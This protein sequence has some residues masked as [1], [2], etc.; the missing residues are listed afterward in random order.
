MRPRQRSAAAIEGL[1]GRVL[2]AFN[3]YIAGLGSG[4]T[5]SDASFTFST[6]G[7]AAKSWLIHWDD[8]TP[9]TLLNAPNPAV[10]FTTPQTVTHHYGFL[11]GNYAVSATATSIV[12]L[13][14][15]AVLAENAAFTG[16]GPNGGNGKEVSG[17]GDNNSAGT[18]I[19]VASDTDGTSYVLS[20]DGKRFAVSRFTPTGQLDTAW[21]TNGT[22]V[23]PAFTSTTINDI[24]KAMTMDK[25][26]NLLYV[27]GTSND[28][29]AVA[30]VNIDALATVP[31][32]WQRSILT[33]SANA[34]WLDSTDGNTKIG[35]AG[36]NSSSQ[37]Q[38]T[39]LYAVDS[40]DFEGT[41]HSAGT[42]DTSFGGG[43]A[44]ATA[45]NAIYGVLPQYSV[46]ASASAI[47]EGDD[48]RGLGL[49]E[50]WF[51]AGTVT[52]CCGSCTPSGGSDMVI[53]DFLQDG[54]TDTSF[55]NGNGAAL[56]NT[57]APSAV[58]GG[59]YDQANAM[60]GSIIDDS[61]YMTLIGRGGSTILSERFTASGARDTNATTG[62]GVL[63]GGSRPGFAWGP[64]GIIYSATLD[65][66]VNKVVAVGSA[67]GFADF[68]AL[69]LNDDG[70]LDGSFG[71]G[72]VL[73]VDFGPY[74][75]NRTDEGR[76]VVVRTINGVI[77]ILVAGYTYDVV[78]SKYKIALV[79]LLDDNSF[80][81]T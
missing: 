23:L 7:Q 73:T 51:V 69:R 3:A 4:A 47:L 76:S 67:D 33:G 74:N 6:T 32:E 34:L 80:H 56:Y 42:N 61:A 37:I 50:E 45:N 43:T 48:I 39:V 62:Y 5:D 54:S 38:M 25:G 8:G 2:Y 41:F 58:V 64:G 81:V 36:T 49:D 14:A 1:E 79:D 19:A 17:L 60:V 11:E 63:S 26:R 70:A 18:S 9:D 77:D 21:A 46:S 40:F 31:V 10:G 71:Q 27:A 24:P 35:I 13:T 59:S 28:K 75:G 65:P 20:I 55:G 66:S 72:G 29:W 30:R 78:A 52:Y 57:A 15:M 68:L 53:V 44:V 12:N 16:G 22:Y